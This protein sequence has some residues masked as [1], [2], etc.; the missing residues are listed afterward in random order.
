MIHFIELN[1]YTICIKGKFEIKLLQIQ[2]D[3]HFD[4]VCLE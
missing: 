2:Q 1:N 3:L 4:T